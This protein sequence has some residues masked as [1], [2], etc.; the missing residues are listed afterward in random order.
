M[1]QH[2]VRITFRYVEQGHPLFVAGVGEALLRIQQAEEDGDVR[3]EL[4][5]LGGSPSKY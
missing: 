3:K 4:G 5:Q 1:L 2:H